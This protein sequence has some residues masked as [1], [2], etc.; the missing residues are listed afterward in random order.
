MTDAKKSFLIKYGSDAHREEELSKDG[1]TQHSNAFAK[2]PILSHD[3]QEKCL[4]KYGSH[5]GLSIVKNSS[6]I[7]PKLFDQLKA[8]PR[9]HYALSENKS[10]PEDFI[11]QAMKHTPIQSNAMREYA[12]RISPKL[13][14][15]ILDHHNPIHHAIGY[16]ASYPL[17]NRPNAEEFLKTYIDRARSPNEIQDMLYRLHGANKLPKHIEDYMVNSKNDHA[18]EAIGYYAHHF[19][20]DSIEKMIDKKKFMI[21]LRGSPSIDQLDRI[22]KEA[23]DDE[24]RR[25]AG[26]MAKIRRDKEQSK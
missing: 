5:M 19:S 14:G 3:H 2:C 11:R 9:I 23:D 8:D 22:S 16:H 10:A 1:A 20:P 25:F 17:S 13:F 6:D 26:N 12:E 24:I 21:A 4:A 7:S 15:E 18:H